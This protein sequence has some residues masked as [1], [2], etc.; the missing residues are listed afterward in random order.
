MPLR[1]T[2]CGHCARTSA[3]FMNVLAQLQKEHPEQLRLV[4][5]ECMA[6]CTEAPVA[7]VEYDFFSRVVAQDFYNYVKNKLAT[8]ST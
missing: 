1:V 3:E 2:Y 6:A 5:L 8:T 4:E 7:M